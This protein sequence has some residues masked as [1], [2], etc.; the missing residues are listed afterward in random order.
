MRAFV[1]FAVATLAACGNLP[2]VDGQK[3]DGADPDDAAT[4]ELAFAQ[5]DLLGSWTCS[6]TTKAGTGTGEVS[7]AS[8]G[9]V[10][11]QMEMTLEVEGSEVELSGTASGSWELKDDLL[12]EEVTK[13]TVLGA[14]VNKVPVADRAFLD[15][16]E[17][18]L[19]DQIVTSTIKTLDDESLFVISGDNKTTCTRN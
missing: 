5:D 14:T 8:G 11:T 17:E 16:L 4:K 2:T 1:I 7:Y 9:R 6:Q 3:A 10:S 18:S 12:T 13:F 15:R 19:E